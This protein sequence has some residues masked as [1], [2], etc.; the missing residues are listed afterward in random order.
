MNYCYYATIAT[1]TTIT[2][3]TYLQN[4]T[5]CQPARH[6]VVNIVFVFVVVMKNFHHF[7]FPATK[8][9]PWQVEGK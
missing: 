6:G 8:C 5:E 7:L 1:T 2:T 3:S 4:V 9:T